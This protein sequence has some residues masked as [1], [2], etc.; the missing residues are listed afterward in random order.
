MELYVF[1]DPT[2]WGSYYMTDGSSSDAGTIYNTQWGTSVDEAVE[3]FTGQ[4]EAWRS[5]YYGVTGDLDCTSLTDQG[6]LVACQSVVRPIDLGHPCPGSITVVNI[7]QVVQ[8]QAGDTVEYLQAAQMPDCYAGRAK[9]GFYMPLRLDE[10]HQKWHSAREDLCIDATN[11]SWVVAASGLE[12]TIDTSAGTH[13]TTGLY[14]NIA[15]AGTQ[16][17]HWVGDRHLAPCTRYVGAICFQNLHED[18][19]LRLTFRGGW[20]LQV[21]PG[22]LQTPFQKPSVKHDPVAEESYFS[23]RR[24]MKDAYPA[25]FNHDGTLWRVIKAIAS[26]LAPLVE[27]IPY[28]GPGIVAAG[29]AIGKAIDKKQK[30]AALRGK[31]KQLGAAAKLVPMPAKGAAMPVVPKRKAPRIE[32]LY[33]K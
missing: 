7:P 16:D 3:T 21:Q 5:V 2:V 17:S 11:S 31:L 24:Q 32:V 8:Y 23:I 20:E 30:R 10:N 9:D 14:P 15:A 33:R 6:N 25:A 1:N 26:T 18:A 29:R 13:K 27:A 12:C 4:T 19:A 28:V 22:T